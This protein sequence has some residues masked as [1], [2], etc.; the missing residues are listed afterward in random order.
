M[1]VAL[2]LIALYCPIKERMKIKISCK[3]CENE[4]VNSVM[5]NH[6]N[7]KIVKLCFEQ[8]K[9]KKQIKK[10]SWHRKLHTP[11]EPILIF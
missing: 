2:S 8:L 4:F 3:Y 9:I 7:Y 6:H 5:C 10:N 1:E 11:D